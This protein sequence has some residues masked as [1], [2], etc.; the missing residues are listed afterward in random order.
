[1]VERLST[2]LFFIFL[3]NMKGD[4]V[5]LYNIIITVVGMLALC[6]CTTFSGDFCDSAKCR[7]FLVD[8]ASVRVWWTPML[9]EVGDEYTTVSANE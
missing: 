2:A 6:S 1:M 7:D 5:R 8:G 9:R 4:C 3:L